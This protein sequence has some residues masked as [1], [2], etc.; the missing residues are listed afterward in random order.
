MK[1]FIVGSGKDYSIENFYTLYMREAGAEIYH[2]PALKL[3]SDY[4]YKNLIN[5]V[6]FKSGISSIYKKINRVF[7]QAVIEFKPDVI[8]VVK[9]MEIFSSS[10]QWAKDK[11]FTL[12]NYNPD[13]PF[14]F[15][16]SGSGNKNITDSIP[17]YD[18]HFAYSLT[19]KK[20]IDDEY[21]IATSFLPFGFDLSQTIF[22][23]CNSQSEILKT[24]FLGNPDKQ[25]GE[26][27]T[28]LAE[29]GITIDV[30]GN[31]WKKFVGHPNILAFPPIIYGPELWRILRVY[32]VQLNLMRIH[33]MDSHNMRSFEVPAIGGIMLAPDTKEHRMFFEME[34]EMFLFSDI[35]SC[36]EQINKIMTLSKIESRLVRENARRRSM[37]D[38]YSYK[39]RAIYAL[40]EIKLLHEKLVSGNYD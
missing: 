10:I 22:D 9:G 2:F 32:R 21:H 8:W 28:S 15:S 38:G 1:I 16:G 13:N 3:F 34:K 36:A 27:L 6:I 39:H 18:M 26:F 24:C 17:L 29:R 30:Y 40:S 25:R 31:N 7:K 33:N 20:R 5:K 4:Y 14:I 12:V 11:K 37:S 35:D 19:T 23:S